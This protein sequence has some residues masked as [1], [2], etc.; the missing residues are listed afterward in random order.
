MKNASHAARRC[1]FGHSGG[2]PS[3]GGCGR[4]AAFHHR[5]GCRPHPKMTCPPPLICQDL[6]LDLHRYRRGPANPTL[7]EVGHRDED[8]AARPEPA[9]QAQFGHARQLPSVRHTP[10]PHP[11]RVPAHPPLHF[12]FWHASDGRFSSLMLGIRAG[13]A[14]SLCAGRLQGACGW[15]RTHE[16]RFPASRRPSVSERVAPPSTLP[17][18]PLSAGDS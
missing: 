5:S 13:R 8:R 6:R 7:Q 4:G 18:A 16:R 11:Q 1:T 9:A 3:P 10:P 14:C 15:R 17:V 2:Q 12:A